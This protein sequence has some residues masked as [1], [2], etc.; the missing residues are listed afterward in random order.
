M[1]ND[2]LRLLRSATAKLIDEA[3][4]NRN[5]VATDSRNF[6]VL[7]NTVRNNEEFIP[8]Y[9][10]HLI[11]LLKRSK[12]ERRLA[13]LSLFDYFFNRS[14][15]FRENTIMILQELL[16]L[17]CEIDPLHHPLPGPPTQAHNLKSYAIKTIKTWHEKFGPAYEK[18]DYVADFLRGS[19]AVDFNTASAELL[20]ERKR[21]AEEEQKTAERMQQIV[22]NVRRKIDVA[23]IDIERTIASAETALSIL[24]PVFGVDYDINVEKNC[25]NSQNLSSTETCSTKQAAHGYT[26]A[27]TISVVLPSLMPEISVS[28]DNETLIESLRDSK[29]MLDTYRKSIVRCGLNAVNNSSA[30]DEICELKNY[31]WQS[32]INGAPHVELLM[33]DLTSIKVKIDQQCQKINELKLKP[34]RRSCKGTQSSDSE[35]SDLELVPEKEVEDF[36]SFDDV[37]Q[38][39]IDRVK[40]LENEVVDQPCCSKSLTNDGSVPA[41]DANQS[42]LRIP[43]VS[44]GLD[45]KYW[46]ERRTHVQVPRNDD[47][48]H[49]LW[50]ASE[51]DDRLFILYCTS[52]LFLIRYTVY[53]YPLR[54]IQS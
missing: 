37:P 48:C 44:F 15:K 47:D 6:K 5:F 9:V 16:L 21:K 3:L 8:E 19:K 34:K 43:V 7:K 4:N 35:E 25:D 41:A 11:I 12:S 45:L 10:N 52:N 49:R 46:G 53:E 14:H 39:I 51:E 28:D 40:Q 27:D 20:A 38:H 30:F 50:R 32:K 13:L 2:T 31:S 26:Y 33:R 54:Y 22:L 23:K 18:L 42:K 1:S 17:V 29:V 36:G 24:V